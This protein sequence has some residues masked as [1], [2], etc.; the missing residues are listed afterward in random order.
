M[1]KVIIINPTYVEELEKQRT[2]LL[3][4]LEQILLDIKN[5]NEFVNE[6]EQLLSIYNR[7]ERVIKQAEGR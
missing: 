4:A 1:K 6:A 7:T 2:D 5:P 3:L